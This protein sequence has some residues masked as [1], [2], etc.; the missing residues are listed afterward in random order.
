MEGKMPAAISSIVL[1]TRTYHNVRITPTLINFFYGKNG[2]GKSTIADCIRSGAGVTPSLSNYEVLVY[3]RTFIDNNIRTEGMSGVFSVNEG[4][5]QIQDEIKEKEAT[6]EK[7]RSQQ[8]G[9]ITQQDALKEKPAEIQIKLET[10]CWGELTDLRNT[11]FPEAMKKKR[12]NKNGFIGEL[13]KVVTPAQHEMSDMRSL[14]E[15]AFSTDSTVYSKMLTVSAVVVDQIA[16][17]ELLAKA[18]TSR[19]DTPFADFVRTLGSMDWIQY[20]HEHFT[21]KTDHR[22]PYCSRTL[23]DDF[24]QQ[25]ASCFDDAYER[26]RKGVAA[27]KSEYERQMQIVINTLSQNLQHPFP[28]NDFSAYNDKFEALKAKHELN[29]SRLIEKLN[30]PTTKISLEPVADILNDLNQ[31]IRQMNAAIEENNAI[32]SKRKIKQVECTDMIWEHMAFLTKAYIEKYRTDMAEVNGKLSKLKG[33]IE[34]I[35][36][37]MTTLRKEISELS[38]QI[39]NVDATM[40]SINNMLI[41]AGFQGFTVK[42]KRGEPNKYQIVRDDGTPAHGLSEGEKN[43]I[44]FLYFYHKIL[45]REKVDSEFKDRIIVIDDPVSSMDSSALFIVSS[46]VRELISICHNNGCAEKPDAPRYIKQIFV[47]THNS[48]FHNE[49]SYNR[50][51][52]YDYHCVNFYLIKKEN[53][54]STITPCTKKDAFGRTPM[55]EQN[56]TPVYNAYKTLWKEYKEAVS[57]IVL[58]QVIRQILEYY[59]IQICGYKGE[60]LS[61]LLKKEQVLFITQNP[62]GTENR[63]LLHAAD[64]LMH[65]VG[66]NIHGLSDGYD[67]IDDTADMDSIRETFKQIFTAMK[68]PQHFDMMMQSV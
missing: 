52:V 67:Y 60:Q 1:N 16:G 51:G 64:S 24:E 14:Y 46:I 3:D 35:G 15:A 65:Y 47:L 62:D 55:I 50:L 39:V 28:R 5:I 59:F 63:D 22:C 4:N 30:S 9:L 20:G 31:I 68:Q 48:F 18:I 12:N 29:M 44:A 36:N 58:K 32:I 19:A 6:L 57:P 41:N 10:D 45:G 17:Y 61:D 33:E 34:F 56:Y 8:A 54:V 49:V 37:A 25:F 27:F 43:F 66:A 7:L 53:N 11:L 13:L 40:N 2:V 38:I 42:K 23:P 26:E 21:D